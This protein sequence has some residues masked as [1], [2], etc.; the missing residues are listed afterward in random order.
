MSGRVAS[1]QGPGNHPTSRDRGMRYAAQA[2]AVAVLL[3]LGLP[4]PSQAAPPQDT[5][6]DEVPPPARPGTGSQPR[7]AP[8]PGVSRLRRFQRDRRVVTPSDMRPARP[9]SG[10]KPSEPPSPRSRDPKSPAPQPVPVAQLPPPPPPLLVVMALPWR[11]DVGPPGSRTRPQDTLDQRRT[12]SGARVAALVLPEPPPVLTEPGPVVSEARPAPTGSEPLVATPAGPGTPRGRVET[13]PA[14]AVLEPKPAGPGSRPAGSVVEPDRDS[15]LQ[16]ARAEPASG[17]GAADPRPGPVAVNPRLEAEEE[18]PPPSPALPLRSPR[19]VAAVVERAPPAPPPAPPVPRR[20]L[21]VPAAALHVPLLATSAVQPAPASGAR[22][23]HGSGGDRGLP[24]ARM[25]AWSCPVR[26]W[27][28]RPSSAVASGRSTVTAR[29]SRASTK[30]LSGVPLPV[31]ARPA[32]GNAPEMAAPVQRV[33]LSTVL[34]PTILPSAGPRT[35]LLGVVASS[36]SLGKITVS[37]PLGRHEAKPV[38]SAMVVVPPQ[39]VVSLRGRMDRHETGPWPL[40]FPELDAGAAELALAAEAV[41]LPRS[42]AP[43]GIRRGVVAPEAGVSGRRRRLP[44]RFRGIPGASSRGTPETQPPPEPPADQLP[45]PPSPA[46]PAHD[47]GAQAV[48]GP[49][50]PAPQMRRRPRGP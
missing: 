45:E 24:A 26:S 23:G 36:L 11:S 10:G 40:A 48:P 39:V 38:V 35:A 33:V 44:Q 8:V 7:P 2:M 42:V 4:L 22:R 13:G 18:I 20:D 32:A 16:A 41:L 49:S 47:S 6:D 27:R 9:Y 34:E 17:A 14:V 3:L 21:V 25:V 12:K 31:L 46:E 50:G 19:P 15:E 29:L 30:T 43:M 5:F 1:L 28:G 37:L